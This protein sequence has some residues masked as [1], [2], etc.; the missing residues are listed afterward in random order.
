VGNYVVN[1]VGLAV[2]LTK[3]CLLVFFQ[4]WVR[5]TLPR[6]RIDQVMM[7]CLKY[8]LPISCFLLLGVTAWPLMLYQFSSHTAVFS[9]QGA[10]AAQAQSPAGSAA[11]IIEPAATPTEPAAAINTSATEV[12]TVS[13]IEGGGE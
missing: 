13:L 12:K 10:K 11:R 2:F 4:M 3:G 6:L 1:L 9:P 7:A 5:W 8:L